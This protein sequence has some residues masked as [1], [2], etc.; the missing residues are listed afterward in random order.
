M[1]AVEMWGRIDWD[2]KAKME[3]TFIGE[4]REE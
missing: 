1:Q 3:G 2:R 4:G